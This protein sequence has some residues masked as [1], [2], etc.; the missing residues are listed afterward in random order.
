M[1]IG[2]IDSGISSVYSTDNSAIRGVFLKKHSS[3]NEIIS[4]K[5]ID[6][7]IGH[8]SEC[9]KIISSLV[10]DVEY[11][12]VKIFDREMISD[13]DLLAAGIQI[14][15]DEGTDVINISA[16]VRHNAIPK[17]LSTCCDEAYRRNIALIAAGPILQEQCFPAYY[18]KVIGVGSTEL[19]IGEL[20]RYNSA[21]EIEFY[22][23]ASDLYPAH[24]T[25][26]AS[27]SFSCAKMTAYATQI[28]QVKGRISLEELKSELI[29]KLN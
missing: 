20:Y 24:V 13:V 9:Y 14:C 2:I 1:K 27:T 7:N 26:S 29:C 15:I 23:S 28:I 8:G 10:N 6:D 25:W 3:S 12:I 17:L 5:S 18:E 22:T 11:F 19:T 21:H 4:S 16:G